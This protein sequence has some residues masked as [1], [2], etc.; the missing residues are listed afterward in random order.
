[1]P[2]T[3]SKNPSLLSCTA[4]R[5]I[6][7]IGSSQFLFLKNFSCASQLLFMHY[8]KL[9]KL[10]GVIQ[11]FPSY[12]VNILPIWRKR[13]TDFHFSIHMSL[14]VVKVYSSKFAFLLIVHTFALL[15]T[16]N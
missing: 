6:V 3:I 2:D 13:W 9:S 15:H 14:S 1:M 10:A 4:G 8:L 7:S 12:L 16:A 11:T 5:P